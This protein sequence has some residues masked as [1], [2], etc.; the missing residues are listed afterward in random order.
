MASYLEQMKTLVADAFKD[1]TDTP[2]IDKSAQM[3]QCLRQL[4]AEQKA[5]LEKNAE[6]IKSY[7]EVVQSTSFSDK[8]KLNPVESLCEVS[9]FEHRYRESIHTRHKY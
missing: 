9:S 6:L 3:E 2:T 7:K 1:A 5:L 8:P 4:E